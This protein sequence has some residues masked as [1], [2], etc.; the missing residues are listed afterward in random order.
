MHDEQHYNRSQCNELSARH[1][2]NGCRWLQCRYVVVVV[3]RLAVLGGQGG[4][5]VCCAVEWVLVL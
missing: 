1:S 3:L 4:I 5:G 2:Q